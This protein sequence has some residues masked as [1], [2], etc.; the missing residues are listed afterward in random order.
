MAS[1]IV[2]WMSFVLVPPP[3]KCFNCSALRSVIF[4]DGEISDAIEHAPEVSPGVLVE[5]VAQPLGV[6][7]LYAFVIRSCRD[8]GA[9]VLPSNEK[10]L[11]DGHRKRASLEV[12][13][14]WPRKT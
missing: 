8:L 3:P 2:W 4:G 6:N 5:T 10:K 9:H 1:P 14:F 13:R 11:S 12:K 7:P